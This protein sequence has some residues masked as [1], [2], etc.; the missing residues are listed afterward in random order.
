MRA[1]SRDLRERIVK[2]AVETGASHHEI[3][4]RFDVSLFSVRRYIIARKNGNLT[5]VKRKSWPKKIDPAILLQDVEKYPDATLLERAGKFGA[6]TTAIWRRLVAINPAFS[7]FIGNIIH[8][9]GDP[10]ALAL[11]LSRRAFERSGTPQT[12]SS[13]MPEKRKKGEKRD[14]C[15]NK[16]TGWEF[17][18]F[19]NEKGEVGKGIAGSKLISKWNTNRG[20]D[21]LTGIRSWAELYEVVKKEELWYHPLCDI[22]AIPRTNAPWFSFNS[23]KS[24]VFTTRGSCNKCAISS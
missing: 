14:K 12:L 10:I 5:P 19:L 4:I 24:R 13:G 21:I 18:P 22:L 3:A 23:P 8:N 16:L 1:Y 17:P 20:A 2:T 9:D 6:S 7:T 15:R 11:E